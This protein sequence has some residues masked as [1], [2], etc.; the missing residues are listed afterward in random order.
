MVRGW[1]M[2]RLSRLVRWVNDLVMLFIL[3]WLAFVLIV[4]I[5]FHCF[6]LALMCRN[7]LTLGQW[8]PWKAKMTSLYLGGWTWANDL[9]PSFARLVQ[10]ASSIWWMW[11]PNDTKDRPPSLWPSRVDKACRLGLL[12]GE[13]VADD[14][15]S[16]AQQ[17]Q[18][19]ATT[20]LRWRGRRAW[21]CCDYQLNSSTCA[22]VRCD[23]H[24]NY[25]HD[26]DRGA[27]VRSMKAADSPE[28]LWMEINSE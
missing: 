3:F 19:F 12:A 5:L 24:I 18:K 14:A 13:G 20:A 10:I 1:Q 6:V 22:H 28:A 23:R 17:K 8:S 25:H 7:R 26:V 15:S 9:S 2:N 21:D 27:K 16:D 11:R 4:L